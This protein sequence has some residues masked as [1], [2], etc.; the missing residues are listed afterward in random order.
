MRGNEP[1]SQDISTE[2]LSHFSKNFRQA[3]MQCRKICLNTILT[4]NAPSFPTPLYNDVDSIDKMDFRKELSMQLPKSI[5]S[6]KLYVALLNKQENIIRNATEYLSAANQGL[7]QS[8]QLALFLHLIYEFEQIADQLLFRVTSSLAD[9]D[10]LTGL[11]NRAAMDRDLLRESAQSRRSGST[12]IIAMIDIDHFKTL[13]DS[14]GHA[15]G[16]RVLE[17][18]TEKLTENFRPRD[19]LYRYGGDEFLLMLPETTLTNAVKV[20]ERL[21]KKVENLNIDGVQAKTS[22]SL[23][24]TQVTGKDDIKEAIKLA[25]KALYMAKQMGRNKLEVITS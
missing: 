13:N 3:V 16:D 1:I 8:R 17:V 21:R 24:A 19:Q 12:F 20:L 15:F 25:D 10:D 4:L 6:L 7:L 18:I 23:G 14:Y 5:E 22:I 2:E 9:T 11:L